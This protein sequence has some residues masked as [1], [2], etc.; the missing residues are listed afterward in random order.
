M[1]PI[2]ITVKR[3]DEDREYDLAVQPNLPLSEVV[4]F[5]SEGLHWELINSEFEVTDLQTGNKLDLDQTLA[6]ANIWH[7]S[8]LEFTP[9][10][11]K[12]SDISGWVWNQID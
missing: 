6:E 10:S 12:P 4:K 3:S 7:G 9:I 8:R 5:I 2:L 1:D 11:R